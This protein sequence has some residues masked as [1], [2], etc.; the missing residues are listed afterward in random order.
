VYR[1]LMGSNQQ[2]QAVPLV[3]PKRPI[4][5]TGMEAKVAANTGQ[6]VQAEDAGEVLSAT[7]EEVKVK[8]KKLGTK[9][10]KPDQFIRTNEGSCIN[11]KVVVSKGDVVKAGDPLI[12]GMS[13]EGGELALGKDLITAFMPWSGYN[14]EDAIIV[15][16]KLVEDDTLSSIHIVDYMTEV[17][18]TKLGPEIVTRDIPNVSEEALRHL[19]DDGIADRKS[20]RLKSSH[21]K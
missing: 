13:I 6:L 10:Y 14:F 12:E 17:R 3:Q 11:Q 21:V 5:G 15:S 18:E 4:V 8:Y 20:T 2:R 1:S 9:T 7:A 19:D 16:R